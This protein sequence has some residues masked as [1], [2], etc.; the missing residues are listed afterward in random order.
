MTPCNFVA[1]FGRTDAIKILYFHPDL[2]YKP[3]TID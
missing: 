2:D 1:Q 3:N